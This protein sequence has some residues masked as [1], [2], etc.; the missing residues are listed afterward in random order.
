MFV[1]AGKPAPWDAMCSTPTRAATLAVRLGQCADRQAAAVARAQELADIAVNLMR[2]KHAISLEA[3]EAV[4]NVLS[5]RLE[6]A[7]A[8]WRS[9]LFVASLSVVLTLGAIL[10]ARY[11]VIQT[12]PEI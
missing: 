3:A 1:P 12:Q 9:P 6:R 10:G 8:F 7:E 11:L 2:Q 4:Q 5:E